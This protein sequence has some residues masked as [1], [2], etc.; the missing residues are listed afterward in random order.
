[1]VKIKCPLCHTDKSKRLLS[2]GNKLFPLNISICWECGFV[3]E[4]PRFSEAEW[5]NYYETDYD[6]FHR[7]LPLPDQIVKNADASSRKIA[8]RLKSAKVMEFASILDI[9]AGSGDILE[10]FIREN[11]AGSRP[12]AIEPSRQCQKT[13]TDKNIRVL[14][15]SLKEFRDESPDKAD[16]IIMR[17]VLE[18]LYDPLES[19]RIIK[20]FMDHNSALYLAVP[21]LFSPEGGTF[22]FPHISY[23]NKTTLGLLAA[24][25]NLSA[26][27]LEE[28]NDE[29]YGIF[30]INGT[31]SGTYNS[32]RETTLQYLRARSE[33]WLIKRLK[34]LL[35]YFIPRGLLH[36]LLIKKRNY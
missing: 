21:N 10:Y 18:H 19:M 2:L 13:L 30:R 22:Q 31:I 14:G 6:T 4:N 32:N 9:G 7:P 27:V 23:F 15:S 16:L 20:G 8:Q 12:L 5:D 25:A 1:M 36:N 24:K 26:L 34:R 17:H 11:P 35:T 29:V 33:Y 28:D 3:F